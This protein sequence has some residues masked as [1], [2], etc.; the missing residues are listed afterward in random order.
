LNQQVAEK[1]GV[2]SHVGVSWKLYFC[3]GASVASLISC[4]V[5]KITR[6]FFFFG[7]TMC[8]R[9][10]VFTPCRI[11]RFEAHFI[12]EEGD[13]IFFHPPEMLVPPYQSMWGP[14]LEDHIMIVFLYLLI[15]WNVI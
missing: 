6:F 15:V 5:L 10:E 14:K 11:H 4:E 9:F 12:P 1:K 2:D 3:E 7:L 8:M 13:S